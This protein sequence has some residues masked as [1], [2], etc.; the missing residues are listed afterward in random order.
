MRKT[1]QQGGKKA[2]FAA[3]GFAQFCALLRYAILAR[4]L[5][6]E[7]LG[8]V[9]IIVLA[10]QLFDS[11]TEAGSDRFLIQDRDGD[12]ITA[13]RLIHLVAAVRGMAIAIA[14]FILARP[15]AHF[16][17]APEVAPA[18]QLLG[19]VPLIA[20][21]TNFDFRA[22]Q[23]DHDFRAEG[24]TLSVSEGASLLATVAAAY[25]VRDF[26]AI[27]YGLTARSAALAI[28]SHLTATRHYGWGYSRDHARRLLKFGAPLMLNGLMLFA[29]TQSDRIIISRSLGLAEL[30]R[31]TALVLLIYYPVG[32]IMRFIAGI[33]LPKCAAALGEPG[34]LKR[35]AHRLA[36]VTF[37]ISCTLAVGFTLVTPFLLP[38]IYRPDFAQPVLTVGLVGLQQVMRL[39]KVAPTTVALSLGA[40]NIVL[41][42]NMA[43]MLAVPAAL[44]GLAVIG[45]LNGIVSGLI[46]GEAIA[47]IVATTLTNRAAGWGTW[48][49]MGRYA[50]FA[51][52][53]V[54]LLG[55]A[56][57][58]DTGMVRT[59][60]VA[61]VATIVLI[62]VIGIKEA[63]TVSEMAKQMMHPDLATTRDETIA[64]KGSENVL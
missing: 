26:T 16:S 37:L 62:A 45:G 34:G 20:G 22:A 47:M 10:A 61:I 49:G 52:L 59:A 25:W 8:L 9:A 2:Y 13:L 11:I 41:V 44:A 12:S 4:I 15:I 53:A 30:G 38:H 32:M 24:W 6:P 63:A 51:G 55:A 46:V 57:A 1:S 29:A 58:F 64:T 28:V 60:S 31:Y 18:L 39:I 54:A 43:R 48:S 14:L 35:V 36:S 56:F 19:L 5:G 3:L 21:F 33:Y 17:G 50:L 27:L 40:T 23:R 42:N 7:Q